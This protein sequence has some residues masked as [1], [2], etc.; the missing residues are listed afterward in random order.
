MLTSTRPVCGDGFRDRDDGVQVVGAAE[1][2]SIQPVTPSRRHSAG[3]SGVARRVRMDVDQAG[4]DELAARIE[5]CG[6][7]GADRGLHGGDAPGRDADVADGVEPQ[8]RIDD[9]AAADDEVVPRALGP[10]PAARGQQ[11]G[12]RGRAEKLASIH[13]R[14]PASAIARELSQLAGP[15]HGSAKREACRSGAGGDGARLAAPFFEP[16]AVSTMR[17]LA[18]ALVAGGFAGVG[19]AEEARPTATYFDDVKITVNA[20]ARADG[21]MRVRVVPENGAA[22]EATL[23]IEKRMHENELARGIVDALNTVLAPEYEADKDGGEHVKIRKQARDAANFSVEIT[24]NAPG[25]S[26][27]L[28]D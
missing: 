22:R 21:F 5:R 10:E 4:N 16:T 25:F 12:A 13:W 9:P 28:E 8:R 1:P 11:C 2:A 6:R 14:T 15:R 17:S 3:P 18:L 23:A 27:V 26:V 24:F 19:V 7:R 20:R